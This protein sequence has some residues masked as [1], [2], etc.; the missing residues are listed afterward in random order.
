MPASDESKHRGPRRKIQDWQ[1]VAGLVIRVFCGSGALASH[2]ARHLRL[3]ISDA[4][5]SMRRQK[6]SMQPFFTILKHALRPL[7]EESKHPDCFFKG[8]RL[9]G[10]DGTTLSLVNTEAV[11]EKMTKCDTRRGKAAFAKMGLGVLVELGSHAPIAAAIGWNGESENALFSKVLGDLPRRC[12]LILDRLYGNAPV[13]DEVRAQC[14]VSESDFLIRVRSKLWGF[15][16]VAD[17][18]L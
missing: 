5:L 16:I 8:L 3:R 14:E 7:C 11:L 10:H 18:E 2:V 1:I 13:L 6:M 15:L 12:L 17:G 4:A 9:I